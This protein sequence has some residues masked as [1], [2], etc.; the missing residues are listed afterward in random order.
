MVDGSFSLSDIH[1]EV[2][3]T[4]DK[5]MKAVLINTKKRYFRVLHKHKQKGITFY[6]LEKFESNL[7]YEEKGFHTI[8]SEKFL[9]GK[10]HISLEKSQIT[11]AL[12][13]LSPIQLDILLKTI[14]LKQSQEQLAFEYGISKSMVRK[15]KHT[16]LEKLRRRLVNETKL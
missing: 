6:E 2:V 14:F 11:E 3:E 15:H 1:I 10:E 12:H 9:V 5:Y 4:A 16:A 7:A 8:D 13:T